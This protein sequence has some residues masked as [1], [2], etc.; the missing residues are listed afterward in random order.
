M[1][2]MYVS[3]LTE[4]MTNPVESIQDA[5][6][7]GANALEPPITRPQGKCLQIT[8]AHEYGHRQVVLDN[9]SLYASQDELP[10]ESI[11]IR[12]R[13]VSL[14]NSP[15]IFSLNDTLRA[16]SNCIIPSCGIENYIA[17]W[18]RSHVGNLSWEL[19]NNVELEIK[20][21]LFTDKCSTRHLKFATRSE[22]IIE[23][24]YEQNSARFHSQVP[25]FT[26]H[27]LRRVLEKLCSSDVKKYISREELCV[28]DERYANYVRLTYDSGNVV[29]YALEKIRLGNLAILHP[30]SG[31]DLRLTASTKRPVRFEPPVGHALHVRDKSRVSWIMSDIRID[32]TSVWSNQELTREIE[33]EF[34]TNHLLKSSTNEQ[35]ADT[36]RFALMVCWNISRECSGR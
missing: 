19:K 31:I 22:A 33:V 30:Q 25:E 34:D 16:D 17:D 28:R 5:K 3:N 21:G 9:M 27:K 4:Q 26:F 6:K 32:T 2:L 10:S 29:T 24:T 1:H 13:K 18:V 7:S 20:L 23:P 14:A 15:K 11:D 8:T 12:P 35:F 36:I